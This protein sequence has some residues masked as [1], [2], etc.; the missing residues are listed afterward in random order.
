MINHPCSLLLIHNNSNNNKNKLLIFA[1]IHAFAGIIFLSR[2]ALFIP[3]SMFSEIM[4]AAIIDRSFSWSIS[5]V[6]RYF[7]LYSFLLQS[8]SWSNQLVLSHS[9]FFQFHPHQPCSSKMVAATVCTRKLSC[10][11]LI[12][13]YLKEKDMKSIQFQ[14]R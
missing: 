3:F 13:C 14:A 10:I 8:N 1:I 5:S 2:F 7:F 4:G 9:G 6:S 11:E 12:F